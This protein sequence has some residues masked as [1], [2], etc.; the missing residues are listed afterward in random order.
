MIALHP[1]ETSA[2]GRLRV[3]ADLIGI[4][5]GDGGVP[6][7][8]SRSELSGDAPNPTHVVAWWA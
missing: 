5:R 2:T 1:N 7:T 3:A 6:S 4:R 8:W